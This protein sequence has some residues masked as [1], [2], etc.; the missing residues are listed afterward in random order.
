VILVTGASGKTGRAVVSALADTGSS[1]R[2]LVHRTEQ[3][4]LL[5]EIGATDVVVGDIRDPVALEA[6]MAGIE[7]CYHICPNVHPDEV[8]IGAGAIAAAQRARVEKFV[9][10]SVLH[11]QTRQMPHHWA[12]L[13][14][15][16]KLFESNLEFTILQPCAYMQNALASWKSIVEQGVFRVPYRPETRVSL[17][18]L[19]DV[20]SIARLVLTESGHSGAIYELCGPEKLTQFELAATL[21]KILNRRVEVV[22]ESIDDWSERARRSGV[23]DQAISTL[24]QMFEYYDRFGFWGNSGV[25]EYLLGRPPTSFCEFAE[26]TLATSK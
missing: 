13:Q 26:R 8:S 15:E 22:V 11:P 12:K 21:A 4:V 16:E 24:V 18:D 25:S 20:A 14:V 17:V 10:H 9:F 5:E 19:D 6:V 7:A 23:G 3:V 1:V 2:G